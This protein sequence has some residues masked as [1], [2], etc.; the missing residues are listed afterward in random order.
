MSLRVMPQLSPRADE[1]LMGLEKPGSRLLV[2]RTGQMKLFGANQ[3]IERPPYYNALD[4]DCPGLVRCCRGRTCRS[5]SEFFC[6]R[7]R[8]FADYGMVQCCFE[9]SG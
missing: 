4:P 9:Q 5:F 8:G 3:A 6:L 1:I 2:S 7:G